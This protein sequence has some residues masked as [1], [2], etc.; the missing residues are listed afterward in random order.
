MIRWRY[1]VLSIQFYIRHLIPTL[2]ELGGTRTNIKIR[3]SMIL[4]FRKERAVCGA[5]Q[6]D[7]YLGTEY[8]MPEVVH[9]YKM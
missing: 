4:I 9:T 3:T 7:V 5:G 2:S 6:S 8:E 1:Q